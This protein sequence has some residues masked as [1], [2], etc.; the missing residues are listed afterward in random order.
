MVFRLIISQCIE[1]EYRPLMH[2]INYY[3][4]SEFYSKFL[5]VFFM[6]DGQISYTSGR[7]E[8]SNFTLVRQNSTD[9]KP[10]DS[11]CI[12]LNIHPMQE[13]SVIPE[14]WLKSLPVYNAELLQL[15]L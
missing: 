9:K 10:V 6:F 11:I 12:S 3:A 15:R 5:Q 13:I 2:L 14:S 8:G 1:N 4:Q 7:T